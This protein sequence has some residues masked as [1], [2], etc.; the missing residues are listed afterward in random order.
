MQ[1]ILNDYS[2]IRTAVQF[3]KH[4]TK[5]AFEIKERSSPVTFILNVL[6]NLSIKWAHELNELVFSIEA[7]PTEGDETH[8]TWKVFR[9]VNKKDDFYR[10]LVKGIELQDLIKAAINTHQGKKCHC[11]PSWHNDEEV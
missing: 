7:Y 1:C 9:K 8:P 2:L 4:I 5:N 11:W 3:L 6:E 10:P